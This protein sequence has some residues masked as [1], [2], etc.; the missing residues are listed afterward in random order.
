MMMTKKNYSTA[1]PKDVEEQKLKERIVTA[2]RLKN[3]AEVLGTRAGMEVVREIMEECFVFSSIFTGNSATYYNAGRHDLGTK[4]MNT[5]T[6][7]FHAGGINKDQLVAFLVTQLEQQPEDEDIILGKKPRGD[8]LN[9]FEN[10][11]VLQ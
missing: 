4:I 9:F 3:W 11:E 5:V 1:D 10:E 2:N 6:R 7:A 8:F